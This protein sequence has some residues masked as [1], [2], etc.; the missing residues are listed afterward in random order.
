MPAIN[1][2]KKYKDLYDKY[3]ME[4]INNQSNCNNQ[5][6]VIKELLAKCE[7]Q[8]NTIEYMGIAIFLMF[9]YTLWLCSVVNNG[10]YIP[11]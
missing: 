11:F 10:T 5:N 9:V 7:K 2:E 8:K 6:K 3:M 4:I 1:Y